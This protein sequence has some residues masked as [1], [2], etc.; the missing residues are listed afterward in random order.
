MEISIFTLDVENLQ[1]NCDQC[2]RTNS[3]EKGLQQHMWL[4][5]N[6]SEDFSHYHFDCCSQFYKRNIW[7]TRK[8]VKK[9]TENTTWK[10][11]R[12]LIFWILIPNTIHPQITLR[13]TWRFIPWKIHITIVCV[14]KHQSPGA[15]WIVMLDNI[16]TLMHIVEGKSYQETTQRD[17]VRGLLSR[18]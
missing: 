4:K 13:A 9:V 1:F 2:N 6:F 7:R 12:R 11:Y 10:L 8:S 18:I 3:S 16:W 5:Q 17:T 14:P 15:T